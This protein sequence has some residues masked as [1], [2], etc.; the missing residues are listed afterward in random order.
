MMSLQAPAIIRSE[1]SFWTPRK[2]LMAGRSLGRR[3]GRLPGG[4]IDDLVGM[5]KA[6]MLCLDCVGKFDKKGADYA[7]KPNLPFVRGRCDG[8]E[9]YAN[10]AHLFVHH[11]INGG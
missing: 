1:R 6:I 8:C 10:R 9:R 2:R 7:T 4:R 5:R 3:P 11:S